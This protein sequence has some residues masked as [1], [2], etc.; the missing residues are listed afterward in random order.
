VAD[1]QAQIDADEHG[2]TLKRPDS[3]ERDVRPEEGDKEVVDDENIRDSRSVTPKGND[4]ME[5]ER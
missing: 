5:E 3:P 4:S 1:A 2:T